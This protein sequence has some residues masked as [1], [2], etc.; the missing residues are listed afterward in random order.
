MVDGVVGGTQTVLGLN[1]DCW[2]RQLDPTALVSQDGEIQQGPTA[3]I[4]SSQSSPCLYNCLFPVIHPSAFIPSEEKVLKQNTLFNVKP[5]IWNPLGP[6]GQKQI[7][8]VPTECNQVTGVS[9]T[10]E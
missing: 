7:Y 9:L 2:F 10:S 6:Q 5:C 8:V 4:S 1:H 3:S